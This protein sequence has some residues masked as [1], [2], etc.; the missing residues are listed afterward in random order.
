MASVPQASI[1]FEGGCEY[2]GRFPG[3]ERAE[4]D[5]GGGDWVA[6][7]VLLFKDDVGVWGREIEGAR[8]LDALISICLRPEQWKAH[9]ASN[10]RMSA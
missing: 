9:R 1:V 10:L 2:E 3:D 4:L 5:L 8:D 7:R 6:W